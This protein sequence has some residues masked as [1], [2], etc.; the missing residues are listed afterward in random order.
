[1]GNLAD[2]G[3]SV[4]QKGINEAKNKLKK[5]ILTNPYVLAGIAIAA[6]LMIVFFAI[7]GAAARLFN[8]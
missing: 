3:K 7:M 6:F 8:K 1:M 2:Y 4:I 5:K